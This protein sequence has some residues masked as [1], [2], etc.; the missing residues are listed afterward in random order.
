MRFNDQVEI[1]VAT[2]NSNDAMKYDTGNA[3]F[4][5]ATA[6]DD[7]HDSESTRKVEQCKTQCNSQSLHHPATI[8]Y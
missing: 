3:K 8:K 7:R 6:R 2:A 5:L 1:D 4:S